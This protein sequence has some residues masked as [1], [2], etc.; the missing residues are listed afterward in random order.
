[1]E[2]HPVGG[3]SQ[4]VF[5]RAVLGPVLFNSFIDDLDKGTECTLSHLADGT[6]LGGSVDLLEHRKALQGDLGSLDRGARAS[7]MRFNTAQCRVLHSG[8]TNPTRRYRLGK[9]AGKCL[10]EKDLGVLL[11]GTRA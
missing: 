2:L 1:M 7:C 5:P 6:E 11:T 8:H 10:V 4:A 9:G 3:R